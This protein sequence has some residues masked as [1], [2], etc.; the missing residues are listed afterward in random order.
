[1][2]TLT[3]IATRNINLTAMVVVPIIGLVLAGSVGVLIGTVIGYGFYLFNNTSI[4]KAVS[5]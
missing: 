4:N 5:K 1:M 2:S 3:Y